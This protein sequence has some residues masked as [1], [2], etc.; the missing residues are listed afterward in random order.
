M[1]TRGRIDRQQK[2]IMRSQLEEVLTIHRNL[3][4]KLAIFQQQSVNSEYRRFWNELKEQNSENV[5]T[6]S[7][8]M[9]LKCNR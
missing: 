9:V 3:D 8:F 1:N 5:K 2:N 4:E 6:I 7:R